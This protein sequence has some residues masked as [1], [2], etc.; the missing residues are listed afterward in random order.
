[1]TLFDLEPSPSMGEG[2]VGVSYETRFA[3]GGLTP[4]QPLPIE[5]RGFEGPI[6]A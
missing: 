2:R 4:P 1:M 3:G 6:P 5:G